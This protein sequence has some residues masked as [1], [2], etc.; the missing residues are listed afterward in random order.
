MY[1]MFRFHKLI[2]GSSGMK[3]GTADSGV[4]VGGAD[5]GNV[6]IWKADAIVRSESDA[7]LHKLD[8][9]TGAVAALDFNPFQVRH[10]SVC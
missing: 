6:F 10:C 5:N 9:H 8:K 7:L 2:W 4:L 3:A 1:L